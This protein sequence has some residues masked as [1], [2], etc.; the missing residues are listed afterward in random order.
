MS[1]KQA[2][3]RIRRTHLYER[4]GV[5]ITA[6]LTLL[7]GLI[8][9]VS[10]IR[11]SLMYHLDIL[12]RHIPL[13][14]RHGGRLTS[15]LAGF[16]LILL[17]GS[18]WRRKRTAWVITVVLVAISGAAHVLKGFD[19][20]ELGFSIGL[21]ILLVVLR[22]SFHAESDRP[23]IR[24][25]LI[26]LAA[27][28]GFTLVYGT[29]GFWFLDKHFHINYRLIDAVRQTIVMFTSFYSPGVQPTSGFGRYFVDSIYIIGFSTIS[30]A[31]LMLIRP[32][33]VRAPAT[34][35][36]HKR[37]EDIITKYGSTSLARAALFAD[38]SYFFGPGETVLAYAVSGRGAIVL[39]DPIGP[40]DQVADAIA[41]FRE[42]C[43]RRDWLPAF[44]SVLP[45]HLQTYQ[46]LGFDTLCIG[47]EAII[48]LR[49]FTLAGSRNKELRN[50][51]NRLERSGY[52][53]SVQQPPLDDTLLHALRELSNA[54]LTMRKSRELHFSDGWFEES[55]IRGSMVSVVH[56]PDGSPVAFAN[57]VP[58]YVKPEATI[59]LMRHYELA[60]RDT[61]EYMFTRILLWAKEQ[62]YDSFSLGLSP[63]VGVGEKPE[64]TRIERALHSLAAY[65]SRFFN[66]RGLHTFKDKFH[67]RWEPRYLAYPGAAYLPVIMNSLLQ[68]HNRPVN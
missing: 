21:L 7:M 9:L 62:G 36:E 14:I 67:P 17:A 1:A 43:S 44:V 39:G 40:S 56:A 8:N 10:A 68:V 57:L 61:M 5:H 35:E 22:S 30:F 59:D 11:P 38:K 66:F 28:F 12:Q 31:A 64:D 60:E 52:Q 27:A 4:F 18:L 65:G 49:E 48:D 32:V 3:A 15:A 6:L 34:P 58:E 41:G 47:Y 55:Y 51:I 50:I 46:S 23:S 33:L 16:A 29:I 26:I 45:E 53:F 54:W 24:Q 42:F 19:I 37:A 2:Q 13:A 63:I 20:V 25:G